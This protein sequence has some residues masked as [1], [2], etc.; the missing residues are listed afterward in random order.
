MVFKPLV[1]KQSKPLTS[2]PQSK[3]E[4]KGARI[5]NVQFKGRSPMTSRSPTRSHLLMFAS[6]T[7]STMGWN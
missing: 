7:D 5:F 2:W 6:L 3:R 1:G 4:E